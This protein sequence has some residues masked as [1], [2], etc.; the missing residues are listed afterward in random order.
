M[1]HRHGPKHQRSSDLSIA[2]L[3]IE[4]LIVF[5]SIQLHTASVCVTSLQLYLSAF[6]PFRMDLL[7]PLQ[8]FVMH[9]DTRVFPIFES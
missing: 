7:Y 8:L 1:S 3:I 9:K 4:Y 5:T 6:K 2:P